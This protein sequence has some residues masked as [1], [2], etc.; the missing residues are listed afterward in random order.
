MTK[1]RVA[2]WILTQVLPPDRAASMVGDWM[3]D[4]DH[5]GNTWFWS[6]VLRTA[7]AGVWGSLTEHPA[8]MARSGLRGYARYSLGIAGMAF[9]TYALRMS[10]YRPATYRWPFDLTLH[11]T[12]FSW[13]FLSGRWI[14]RREPGR[15]VS[16]CAAAT[17]VPPP[18]ENTQTTSM[19]Y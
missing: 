6:C 14:A 5:R 2:E 4:I 17:S 9:L 19:G 8:T 10:H 1:S 15:E 11:L 12:W 16:G 18:G 3:E 7:I 13:A